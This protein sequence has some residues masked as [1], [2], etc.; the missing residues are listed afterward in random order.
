ME[1]LPKKVKNIIIFTG[2]GLS[3]ES[4]IS[5]FR[6]SN[7]LWEN[8]KIEDVCSEYS[9]KRNFDL[10]HDF[11]NQRRTQLKEVEP[12]EAHYNI[13][14]IQEQYGD[15]VKIITQNVDDLLERAGCKNVLHVHGELDKMECQNCAHI[16]NMN[17]KE[18]D[19]FKMECPNCSSDEIK[20]F[21]VFFGGQAPNYKKMFKTFDSLYS[22]LNT[23]LIVIGT[24]GN[25]VDIASIIGTNNS[26]YSKKYIKEVEVYTI[27]NNLEKSEYLPEELFDKI[28][29]ENATTATN[30]ILKLLNEI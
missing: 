12:N 23:I 7:G 10:V 25:V 29:Y 30:K 6:D 14:K 5:T 21:I 1:K 26:Y 28:F 19:T 8:H 11:Y 20:P 2:A 16:W 18:W 3:A 4:G 22:N 13:Q 17:Y 9:W 27:L 24:M 15:K